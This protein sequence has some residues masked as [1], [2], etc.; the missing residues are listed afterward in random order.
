MMENK[1]NSRREIILYL[2]FGIC[3]TVINFAVFWIL[4][5]ILGDK[6]YLLNNII[7]WVFAVVF[8][9]ITN[10]LLVFS[11]K[12]REFKTV[13][14]EALSFFAARLFSLAVE[15]FGLIVFVEWL[16]FKNI[17]FIIFKIDITGQL[18]AKVILAVIVVILNYFFS[19][20]LIFTKSRKHIDKKNEQQVK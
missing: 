19:K 20:F 11:S 3:T 9:F 12:S 10:K 16:K 17:E 6:Y 1:K 2:V 7:A 18:I 4:N 14:R 13:L 5:L 15:E 8:A